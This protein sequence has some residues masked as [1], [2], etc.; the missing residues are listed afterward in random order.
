M[1]HGLPLCQS[2]RAA[3][4]ARF[5]VEALNRESIEQVRADFVAADAA[6]ALRVERLSYEAGLTERLR[7]GKALALDPVALP[8]PRHL[9]FPLDRAAAAA[10]DEALEVYTNTEAA[11][12]LNQ[13]GHR[14]WNGQPYTVQHVYR[15]RERAGIKGHLQRRREQLREQGYMTAAEM[16]ERLGKCAQTSGPGNASRPCTSFCRQGRN[17][18]RERPSHD[19]RNTIV[20]RHTALRCWR[21]CCLQLTRVRKGR[22]VKPL[23]RGNGH[24]PRG[25]RNPALVFRSRE[26]HLPA[27][28]LVSL[29]HPLR[30]IDALAAGC[31]APH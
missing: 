1:R 2:I 27:Q 14:L 8:K 23:P 29:H 25:E 16:A 12:I 4:V 15:L 21:Q 6:R 18:G 5:A 13:A 17:R 28:H 19:R 24:T 22:I 26:F 7:G 20:G 31:P 3:A 10:L 9:Q 30:P 11:E